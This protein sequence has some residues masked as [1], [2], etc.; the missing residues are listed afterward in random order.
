ML[1]GLVV[2][3]ALL[4]AAGCG[5]HAAATPKPTPSVSWDDMGRKACA[6]AKDNADPAMEI[7]APMS[8]MPEMAA[9]RDDPRLLKAWC[10]E[11]YH[12]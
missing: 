9:L 11:N 5:S 10:A 7:D 12:G 3:G 4:L 1:R 8:A 2:T 6:A